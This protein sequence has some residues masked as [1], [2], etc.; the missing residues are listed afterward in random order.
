M[1]AGF[2][3]FPLAKH[4][5]T[6]IVGKT[7]V[8]I[9]HPP[10]LYQKSTLEQIFKVVRTSK[11][12]LSL[13]VELIFWHSICRK[14]MNT[15]THTHFDDVR[16]QRRTDRTS[17][18]TSWQGEGGFNVSYQQ[19]GAVEI[20]RKVRALRGPWSS[21]MFKYGLINDNV[22]EKHHS[23]SMRHRKAWRRLHLWRQMTL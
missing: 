14:Y 17:F 3:V 20:D 7:L 1:W 22:F 19:C 13:L 6:F 8:N 16:N 2:E 9:M 5:H 11:N 10:A 15:H 18:P 21:I 4:T 12:V 23:S